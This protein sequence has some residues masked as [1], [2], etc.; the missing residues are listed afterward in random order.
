MVVKGLIQCINKIQ[1]LLTLKQLGFTEPY[2]YIA[3]VSTPVDFNHDAHVGG[4][5][6]F[7][8]RIMT[9]TLMIIFVTTHAKKLHS[10]GITANN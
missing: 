6:I 4:P 7:T 2:Y 10:G 8:Q 9:T 5:K 3:E 1:F